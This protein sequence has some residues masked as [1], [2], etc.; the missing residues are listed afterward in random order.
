MLR[1]GLMACSGRG[2][3]THGSDCYSVTDTVAPVGRAAGLH[4][5]C[6]VSQ[7]PWDI[8][9]IAATMGHSEYRSDHGIFRVSQRP[10]DL[11]GSGTCNVCCCRDPGGRK[12]LREGG[13]GTGG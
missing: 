1:C 3:C 4:A 10:W 5:H 9:S 11:H 7:R 12:E 8:Q 2:V 6:R 13:S